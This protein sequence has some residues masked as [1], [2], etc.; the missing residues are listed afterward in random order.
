MDARTR[1]NLEQSGWQIG[2]ARA[3]LELTQA[4]AEF[5]EIKLALAADLRARRRALQLTRTQVARIIGSSR[6]QIARMEAPDS[7]VSMDLLIR[8]L[9]ELGARRSDIAEGFATPLAGGA[10]ER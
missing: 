2:D 3:F 5:I 6:S 10:R 1:E 4:E 7:S 8:T 9:L